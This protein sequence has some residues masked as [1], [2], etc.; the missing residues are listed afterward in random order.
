MS[1]LRVSVFLLIVLALLI[2]AFGQSTNAAVSGRVADQT[3]AAV[4]GAKVAVTNVNTGVPYSTETNAVGFYSVDVPPGKYRI[5]VS[6]DGFAQVIKPDIELHVQDVAGINFALRVGSATESVT[7]EGGAPL[8]NTENA[9]VSTVIDRRFVEN[10][11][12]N[13]R[14]FQPLIALTPGVVFTGA[15]AYQT[16]S[17]NSGGT[18]QF[19]VNGQR[20]DTNSFTVDGV[21]ANFGVAPGSFLG[22]QAAG[23]IGGTTALGTTQSLASLDS[24]QE[25]RVLTSNYSAEFG[26]QPGGQVSIVTRSGTNE[27][28]GLLFEY[29]RNDVFDANDWFADHNH[30]PKPPERQ[31]DFGGTLGGPLIIPGLYHGKNKT[32]FFFSYEGLR[33]RLPTFT[34]S[35]VPTVAL[36]ESAA[37]GL[38][39][40]L[41]AFPLPNGTDLGNGFAEFSASYSDPSQLDAT[42]IRIDHMVTEKWN[43]FGRYNDVPSEQGVRVDS[44]L[45]MIRR[46]EQHAR[47]VTIGANGTLFGSSTNEFR[48]NYT[49]NGAKTPFGFDKQ[50]YG[51]TPITIDQILPKQYVTPTTNSDTV[52]Y[53]DG[54]TGAGFGAQLALFNGITQDQHLWN[55]V[56]NFSRSLGNH[57]LKFGFDWRRVTPSSAANTYRVDPYF[58]SIG[59]ILNNQSDFG[60]IDGSRLQRPIFTNISL[61]AQDSWKITRRL[62]LD[63]GL[64]W[65]VNPSPGEESGYVPIA[66]NSIA[67]LSTMQ[68]APYG[69][70]A[71]KTTYKNF[72][73]RLGF[74]YLLSEHS[75]FETV[76]RGG[77]GLFYDT[78]NAQGAAGMSG[79]YQ[80]PFTVWDFSVDRHLSFPLDPATVTPLAL[81]DP[82]NLAPPYGSIA[83]FDPNLKLPY[84]L[85]WSV[86]IEQAL[87]KDQALA[88]TY[89][90]NNGRKLLQQRQIDLTGVNPDF[91]IIGLTT[92]RATS[93][94]NALQA[95]F[96]RRLSHGLQAIASYSWSHA[97]DF[98]STDNGTILPV[99]GNSAYDVRHTI[100][101]ALTY[102]VP[103]PNS[104][105]FVKALFGDWS[106]DS[107]FTARS[108]LPLDIVAGQVTNPANGSLTGVRPDLVAGQPF[109]IYDSSL[110]GGRK[111][112]SA[113]FVIPPDGQFGNIGRNVIRGLGMW[114][115]D[116]AIQRSFKISDR[117]KLQF[118]AEAFNLYNHPNFGTFQT[119]L[120]AGNFGEATAMLNS[121]LSSGGSAGKLSP[122]YA[123]GGPR[124]LQFALR[125]SF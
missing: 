33:L 112:N 100:S 59:S 13:G 8:V 78:G 34:L 88:I 111:I 1:L 29:L 109:Y 51:A 36:R 50:T 91:T 93:D 37:P 77:F 2:P 110:P 76:V 23:N 94:Y 107:T 14:T 75:N 97:L 58:F 123:V 74:A 27:L 56:D 125:L 3:G 30:Q 117:L 120:T 80:Y 21:S 83:V 55:I 71:W 64:R 15:P 82:N 22:T 101:T 7:V 96:H 25:F 38:R 53:T 118:R 18:G 52:F 114:Q 103:M 41:K 46:N 84:T 9:V 73:P 81:P 98:D 43:L 113:G 122:L 10:I 39:P 26:R 61:F 70:R 116:L 6:K 115:Q 35:N 102:E 5:V 28:H 69:T 95:Q 124:S 32:F 17:G 47:T 85:G 20:S 72:A 54:M 121:A 65:D 89:V 16:G 49:T 57:R 45:A 11:P 48:F 119:D 68:L 44:N 99:R 63:I 42:S 62:S 87:G 67:N 24:M 105:L 31:N 79:P 104:Q 92:N 66:V 12:L 19:S 108:G 86:A 106:F 90:G 60:E 40:L 4:P